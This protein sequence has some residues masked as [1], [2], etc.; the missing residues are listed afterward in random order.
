MS[1]NMEKFRHIDG[2]FAVIDKEYMHI[3]FQ[4]GGTPEEVGVNGCKVEDLIEVIQDK[5]L[6]FQGRELACEENATALYHL[7]LARE[8][9]LL[10]RRRREQQGVLGSSERHQSSD[11]LM[12]TSPGNNN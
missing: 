8:A 1:E 2:G 3:V 11:P 6:D 9:L 5:L 4:H 12:A 10:R 7:D